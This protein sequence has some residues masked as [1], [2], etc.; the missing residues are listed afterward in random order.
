MAGALH[1]D[2]KIAMDE[3]A[4]WPYPIKGYPSYVDMINDQKNLP[5]D[6][7]LDYILIVTPN[8]V[9][10]DPALK[11]IEA[12]IPVMC[13]KPLTVNRE[14]ADILTEEATK[15]GL[16]FAVAHT[17]LGHWTSWLSRFIVTSGLLGEIRWADASYIQGWLAKKSEKSANWRT[18]PKF[19]GGSLCLGDIGT[20]A[21]MQLR[22]VTGLDVTKVSA[23]MESVVNNLD[24]HSTVYCELSNG[25]KAMVRAS[26]ISIGHKNDLALEVV[27][28]EGT[29]VWRQEESEKVKIMLPGQP[30]RI[31]WR[32]NVMPN[33]G[34]FKD[35]PEALLKEPKIPA[36][37]ARASTMPTRG[38]TANLK[39]TFAH[40]R[41]A[42]PSRTTTPA[43]RLFST[44][45]WDWPLSTPAWRAIRTPLRGSKSSSFACVQN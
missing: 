6:E 8:F 5:D 33:D 39:K 19:S 32:G 17:Y 29:L 12:G 42:N 41:K 35:I 28:S 9:H 22:F 27:G 26:Q 44:G 25:A 21:L 30:D 20:H 43:T 16:P 37:T 40:G 23:H 34:F 1:P 7:K 11:A 15:R 14:Q 24:D 4:K 13:E 3:A 45:A 31:Y 38:S 10:F 18:D 2:P 36:A